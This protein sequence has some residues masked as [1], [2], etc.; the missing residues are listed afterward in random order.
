MNATSCVNVAQL[1]SLASRFLLVDRKLQEPEVVGTGST[2]AAS[3]HEDAE[4][5]EVGGVGAPHAGAAHERDVRHEEHAAETSSAHARVRAA[6]PTVTS[7]QRASPVLSNMPTAMDSMGLN[8]R[9]AEWHKLLQ[10]R[11]PPHLKL[12]GSHYFQNKVAVTETVL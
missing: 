12:T 4:A 2:P 11:S 3:T 7:R 6:S 5:D 8:S 10:S 1:N 9:N